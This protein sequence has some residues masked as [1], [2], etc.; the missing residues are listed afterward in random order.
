[1]TQIEI[2]KKYYNPN[3]PRDFSKIQS[4]ILEITNKVKDKKDQMQIATPEKEISQII[5]KFE[6]LEDLIKEIESLVNLF[7]KEINLG[8]QFLITFD[9]D[10]E[11]LFIEIIFTRNEKEQMKFENLTTPEKVF[12]A[13]IFYLCIEMLNNS[14]Y[15]I[16]SNL[17]IPDSFNKRGSTERTIKKILPLFNKEPRLLDI[18]LIFIIA[19]LDIKSD[20]N[21]LKL[22]EIKES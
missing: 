18:S 19:N 21:N 2:P 4:K 20:I 11:N 9:K 14:T 10:Q 5:Q 7:L 17:H 6:L 3:N 8:S 1:L 13:I 22:I 15:I 12:F 16:F